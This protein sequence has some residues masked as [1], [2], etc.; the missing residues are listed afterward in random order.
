MKFRCSGTSTGTINGI[1]M[2]LEV[3]F[4]GCRNNCVN[5][6]NPDLQS[7]TGG[8]DYETDTILS[9]LTKYSYFYRSIV[10]MGGEPCQQPQALYSIAKH[11]NLINILYTGLYFNDIP[12]NIKDVM[13]IIID[14]PYIESLKSNFPASSN[15]KVYANW[16]K[17]TNKQLYSFMQ[18]HN[19]QEINYYANRYNTQ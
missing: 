3:F 6:Q 12:E 4:Q 17:I 2:S 1:G 14:G 18:S 9:E 10:F 19:L 8:Y 7:E 11:S 13:H 5:C 15:Q 16:Y